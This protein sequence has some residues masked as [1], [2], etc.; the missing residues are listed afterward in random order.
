[1]AAHVCAKQYGG[2]RKVGVRM[3]S[4]IKVSSKGMSK[5]D[6]KAAEAKAFK[7]AVYV[8]AGKRASI[9]RKKNKQEEIQEKI[10]ELNRQYMKIQEEIDRLSK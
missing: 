3:V 9:T 5:A 2:L 6:K 10:I 4:A 1:M 8:Q 7:K